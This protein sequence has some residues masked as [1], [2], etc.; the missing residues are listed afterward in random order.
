[1]FLVVW[2]ALGLVSG[3]VLSWVV[4]R[5]D[6]AHSA[7][8]VLGAFGALVGGF[9]FNV[10]LAQDPAGFRLWSL[11]AAMFGALLMIAGFHAL[12]RTGHG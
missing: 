7:D 6:Q 4:F 2:M 3:G 12:R 1:M 9:V 8:M 11:T 5:R 10:V